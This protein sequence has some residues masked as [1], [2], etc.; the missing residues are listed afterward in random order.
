[1]A[2]CPGFVVERVN[3][4]RLYYLADDKYSILDDEGLVERLGRRVTEISRTQVESAASP[5]RRP[6][7][8]QPFHCPFHDPIHSPLAAFTG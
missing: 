5:S 2:R 3:L 8:R 4:T 6:S 7:T 1:M